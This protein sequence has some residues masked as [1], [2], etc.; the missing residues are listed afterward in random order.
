M[1]LVAPGA[2]DRS[3]SAVFMIRG[4]F[5]IEFKPKLVATFG[6]GLD[7]G[8]S[9]GRL[10]STLAGSTRGSSKVPHIPQKRKVF[11]LSSPHFGQITNF[12]RDVFSYSLTLGGP[13]IAIRKFILKC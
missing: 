7:A 5:G 6:V 11:E 4:W 10:A 1:G 8:A 2:G 9:T 3:G 13:I 12:L